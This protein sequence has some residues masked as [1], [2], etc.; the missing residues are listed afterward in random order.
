MKMSKIFLKAAVLVDSG[1]QLYSCNAIEIAAGF[2]SISK[3]SPASAWY[4]R[5][6]LPGDKIFPYTNARIKPYLDNNLARKKARVIALC[7]ASAICDDE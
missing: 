5:N 7:F 1:K 4:R 2:A 6:I 3:Y